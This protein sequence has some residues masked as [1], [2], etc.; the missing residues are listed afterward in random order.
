MIKLVTPDI[1]KTYKNTIKQVIK[2]LNKP[3][4]AHMP[5]TKTDCP[6][7]H[8]DSVN[9][10]SSGV[11]DASFVSSMTI[12]GQTISPQP[13]T[14]GR[15]PV[16]YGQG[17]LEQQVVQPLKALVKWNPKSD[18][19]SVPTPAGREGKPFVRIKVAREDYEY[20]SG[21]EYF[22]VDGVKCILSGGPTPRGLG[23]QE[24]LIVAFLVA[25]EVGSDVKGS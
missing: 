22:I 8:F 1:R 16:C 23:T 20:V 12:Y 21:A 24:E 13:F 2:E 15:C 19:V 9:N 4:T 3:I 17:V 7:C 25:V 18:D 5:S 10:M 11:F 14:R 6:N